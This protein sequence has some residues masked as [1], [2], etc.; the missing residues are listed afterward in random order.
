MPSALKTAQSPPVAWLLAAA[1]AA[2][3][4]VAVQLRIFLNNEGVFTWMFAG[5]T[6]ESPLELIFL[7][8]ARP[9]ISLLYA[10]VAAIGFTP[11]LWAHVLVSALAL[12][13]TAGL[14]RRIGHPRPLLAALLVASSPMFFA[15]AVAGV[16]NSEAVV[17]VV[18]VAWLLSRGQPLAA[19][20]LLGVVVIARVE[21]AVFA[22]A[23]VAWS[24][25]TPD[26]R[27]LLP[28]LVLLP[29]LFAL[30]GAV[31]HG[32]LLWPLHYPS[33]LFDN[34]AV[35]PEARARYGGTPDDLVDTLLGL[36][37]AL[38]L[39]LWLPWRAGT[40]LERTLVGA[41]I[42]FLIAIRILPFTHLVY[43]DASP[44][45]VL[46][47]LPFLALG[48]A[49]A[50]DAL[51][52]AGRGTL[53]RAALLVGGG[54]WLATA[55]PEVARS[56]WAAVGLAVGPALLALAT[57]SAALP[58]LAAA[59]LA[60]TVAATV[61]PRALPLLWN[62]HLL[63]G[64]R[65][66]QLDEASAWITANLPPGAVVVTDV[67]LLARWMDDQGAPPVDLRHVIEPD[68]RYEARALTNPATRQYEAIFGTRRFFYAPWIVVEDIEALPG[69]VYFVMR[70]DRLTRSTVQLGAPFD[71][72]EW[73]RHDG[74][75]AGR[76]P[77]PEP[78]R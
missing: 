8:K 49:R 15:G 23:L 46:P 1:F 48:M 70:T 55:M 72:V 66:R 64:G 50:A 29:A 74:W 5:L 57:P 38:G 62:P 52:A 24:L 44:R 28:G 20:L 47:A 22:L 33:S 75:M 51:P 32:D 6:S 25:R 67:H 58:A 31:Y 34:P 63:L 42:A 12:P 40:A 53:W 13:L 2:A 68:M 77:R 11:F 26:W 30:A 35:S 21:T 27:R 76:L 65:A 61:V 60:L 17:G 39:L 19:G 14:A 10:P 36:T 4:I 43:V 37:P 16:Q 7:L 18:A 3:G 56:V 45:Y 59:A 78:A 69:E 54:A 73:E 9:P 71:R 41:A